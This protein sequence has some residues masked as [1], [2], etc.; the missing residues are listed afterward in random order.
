MYTHK[1]LLLCYY[2]E[3]STNYE[4]NFDLNVFDVFNLVRL[5]FNGTLEF[6]REIGYFF[7][8]MNLIA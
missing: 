3:F 7:L 4:I 5:E 6:Y 2:T 1:L 8:Y